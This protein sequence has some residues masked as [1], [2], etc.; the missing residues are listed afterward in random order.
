MSFCTEDKKRFED[1]LQAHPKLAAL[2]ETYN[3]QKQDLKVLKKGK[4]KG[5]R[6]SK[7]TKKRSRQQESPASDD[8]VRTCANSILRVMLTAFQG[9]PQHGLPPASG[10]PSSCVLSVCLQYVQ[11]IWAFLQCE[12]IEVL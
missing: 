11:C 6:P 5:T 9:G 7:G 1:Q 10:H 8:E 4:G 2:V 3:Q 12:L